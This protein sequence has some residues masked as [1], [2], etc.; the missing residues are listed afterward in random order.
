M[1]MALLIFTTEE[2]LLQGLR[3]IGYK[4]RQLNRVRR[5]TLYRRF[6]AHFGSNPKVY[7]EIW[8]ALQQTDIADAKLTDPSEDD[9]NNYMMALYFMK[10]YPTEEEM[11]SRF[12]V[13]EQTARKWVRFYVNKLAAYLKTHTELFL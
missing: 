4:P 8:E 10:A 13:H 12:G 2:V 11:S 7:A 3:L 5:K 6:K 1:T 9:F